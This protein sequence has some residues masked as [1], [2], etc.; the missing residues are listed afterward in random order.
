[1]LIKALCDYYDLLALEGK[2][3]PE[4]YSKVGIHYLVCLTTDGKIDALTDYQEKIEIPAAKGKVK[5]K[6]VPKEIILPQ[7][8]EKRGIDSNIIEHKARHIFGLNYKN[9]TLTAEDQTGKARKSHEAFV[10]KNMEFIEGLD[11]PV[12]NAYRN[13]LKSWKPEEE[14]ENSELL[15][16]GK[17]YEDSYFGFCLT[18]HPDEL[19]HEDT[20]I[21]Q[22]W[23]HMCRE[24]LVSNEQPY[25]S[26]CAISGEKAP[27][28][29]LH[30]T[31]KG[32]EGEYK[33]NHVLIGYNNA[34][35]NS[36][37]KKQSY[38]SNISETVMKKYTEALNLLLSDSK[39]KV[40]L[41]DVTVVFW[42]MNTNEAYE[43]IFTAMLYG[44]SEKMDAAE[45]EHM[46]KDLLQSGKKGR[47]TEDRLQSL[48][49]IDTDV[50]FYMLGLKPNSSRLSVKFIYRK[51]Y[52]EVLWNIAQF[53][54]DLRVSEEWKPV[55]LTRIKSELL[56]PKSS[57]EKINPALL[58]KLLEAVLYGNP[59]PASLLETTVRR[60]KTDGEKS[61]NG[62]RAGIIKACLNRKYKKHSYRE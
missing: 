51:K 20:L 62:V 6:R 4:G 46:L 57:S 8:T 56:S 10:K 21:K 27:I 3:L 53:Q 18:G 54:K 52:A 50:D 12:I 58:T 37:G 47:I 15:E 14:T 49:K 1:M 5:E 34:S 28:A 43:D 41:D 60:A 61:I 40:L 9:G 35:E 25:F 2:I 31:I 44:Q 13:F 30:N 48:H 26:Q 29:R 23:E 39:H 42:A 17:K 22:K 38:N 11:S 7:R 55:S 45:T 19:L 36:Y 59:Y 24:K 32:V 33:N 16:L